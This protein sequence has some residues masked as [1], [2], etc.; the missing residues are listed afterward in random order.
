[1]QSPAS[2]PITDP[3]RSRNEHVTPTRVARARVHAGRSECKRSFKT[4]VYRAANAIRPSKTQAKS[5]FRLSLARDHTYDAF[6]NNIAETDAAISHM[7]GYT[8]REFDK[9]TGLQYNRARYYDP[10]LGRWMSKDPIGFSGG[11]TNL[12]RMTGNY[13]YTGTYKSVQKYVQKRFPKPPKRPFRRVET[14]AAAQTQSDWMDVPIRLRTEQ[15]VELVTLYGF[16]MTLSHSR[17]SAV[18]WSSRMDQL[19]WHRV[20]N[21]AFKR[22]GG[23]AAVNRIDNLKTGVARGSGVWGE[24]NE[25]YSA[26]ART[27][28][29]HVDP[30]QVRKPNQKGKVERRVGVVR[31]SWT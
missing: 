28:G 22:L 12:Y 11:D 23:I 5:A 9:E 1:M 7:Y 24:I 17:K 10:G 19:A 4:S 3:S 27:M 8:G 2:K 15:G 13:H 6:G 25:A 26:Y 16:V 20:H 14:P 21:E 29:F 18:I 31:Q 30:H